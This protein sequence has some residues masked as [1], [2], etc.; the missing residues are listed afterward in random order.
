MFGNA[1]VPHLERGRVGA[2][3]VDDL[4][5]DGH[6]RHR[7]GKAVLIEMRHQSGVRLRSEAINS[8]H[9]DHSLD[10]PV[11]RQPVG[12]VVLKAVHHRAGAAKAV[13][14]T[15]LVRVSLCGVDRQL[16]LR[17]GRDELIALEDR[18]HRLVIHP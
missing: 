12:Q 15:R 5:S 7:V 8:A 6:Q 9:E 18:V 3:G 16:E 14:Q 17:A 10:R 13:H 1:S 11:H 4:A 2:V